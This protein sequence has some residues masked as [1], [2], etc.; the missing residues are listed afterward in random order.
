MGKYHSVEILDINSLK[1][2]SLRLGFPK[3]ILAKIAS[4]AEH[5]Y[6]FDKEPKKSGGFRKISKPHKKLKEIQS[7][8]HRLLGEVSVSDCAHGGIKGRSNLTNA[9]PHCNQRFLLNLDLKNFFPS[10]SHY[11]VYELFHRTLR[12]SSIVASLLTRLTTVNRQVPQ[13]GPMSTGLVNLILRQTDRRLEKLAKQYNINYTRFV[14]DISFS[15]EFIPQKFKKTAKEIIQQSG[16]QLNPSKEALKDNSEQKLVT[17]LSVN[18]KRPNVPR[19]VRRQVRKEA[20]QFEK[21]NQ[22]IMSASGRK[23]R[24]QQIKGKIA[25]IN[26]INRNR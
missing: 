8:I 22:G 14:D 6:T 19:S 25:Y 21:Y 13:G 18:R 11:K 26:Y 7:A 9:Q 2:L 17:G 4:K 20:H 10:I 15:G 24:D 5:L 12:C 1:H 23:K 16:F 3:D